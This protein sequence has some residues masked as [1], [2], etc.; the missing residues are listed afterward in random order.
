MTRHVLRHDC[1]TMTPVK[2]PK[3]GDMI[4]FNGNYFCNSIDAIVYDRQK[5]DIFLSPGTCDWVYKD[6][7]RSSVMDD[8]MIKLHA[9][10]VLPKSEYLME[11]Q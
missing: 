9:A 8:V 1:A 11:K 4:V 3:C 10:G 5:R 7:P 2:C 6:D